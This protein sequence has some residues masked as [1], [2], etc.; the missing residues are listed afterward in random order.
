MKDKRR[1]LE[2]GGL[3]PEEGREVKEEGR[4]GKMKG[5]GERER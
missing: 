4:T 3:Q 2:N 5:H 1:R